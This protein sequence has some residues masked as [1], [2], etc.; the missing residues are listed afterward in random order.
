MKLYAVELSRHVNTVEQIT[1]QLKGLSS[2]VDAP[3]PSSY[4]YS[5]E[6]G[7]IELPE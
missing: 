1:S 7:T 5:I 3:R 6:S 2:R 4:T